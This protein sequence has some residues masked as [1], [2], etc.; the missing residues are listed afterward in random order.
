MSN[1]IS[2]RQDVFLREL[3]STFT[4]GC[5]YV[6]SFVS[7]TTRQVSLHKTLLIWQVSALPTAEALDNVHGGRIRDSTTILMRVTIN[8]VRGEAMQASYGRFAAGSCR[9][10]W[11]HLI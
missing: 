11:Q 9:V 3:D 4:L 10:T 1:V 5:H 6:S 7:M 2:C 8:Q